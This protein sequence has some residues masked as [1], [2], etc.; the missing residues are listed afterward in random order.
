MWFSSLNIFKITEG[1]ITEKDLLTALPKRLFKPCSGAEDKSAGW[2]SPFGDKYDT[3]VHSVMGGHMFCLKVE[4]KKIPSDILNEKLQERLEEIQIANP[5]GKISR[6]LKNRLKEEVRQELVPIALPKVKRHFAYVD[7]TL[8]YII[9]NE[10]SPSKAETVVRF[11]VNEIDKNGLSFQAVSTV[12]N[13]SAKMSSWVKDEQVPAGLEL[14]SSCKIE[15]ELKNRISYTKHNM[16]DEKLQ[17]YLLNDFNVM[18]LELIYPEK[19]RF[20]LT[21]DF[22][23][24]SI[25]LEDELKTQVDDEESETLEQRMD[26]EFSI[27]AGIYREFIPYLIDTLGGEH[28]AGKD[29]EDDSSSEDEDHLEAS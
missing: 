18:E 22:V 25:K 13:V 3:I 4:E 12:H 19:F 15:S 28:I 9:V 29:N 10:P 7:Q 14:S 16:D 1:D 17:S 24:K 23:I 27:M 5:Q 6:E 20:V 26:V 21:H 11:L 2:V 8:N